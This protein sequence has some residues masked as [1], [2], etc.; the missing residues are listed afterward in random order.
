[1]A[2]VTA[3]P[4]AVTGSVTNITA[5]TANISATVNAKF[6]ASTPKLFIGTNLATIESCAA[7]SAPCAPSAT[8][9]RTASLATVLEGDTT[10]T[11]TG[12]I[13][14]LSANTTY[15]T[16]V[17]AQS[18]AGYSCGA[19]TT[20]STQLSIANNSMSATVN[21]FFSENLIANGGSGVYSNWT[22]ANNTAL[23]S[24]LT[25][26]ASTGVISGTPSVAT[27]ASFD[28][29]V[30][31]SLNATVIKTISIVVGSA[32]QVSQPQS[33][34]PSI[35]QITP[36]NVSTA[37]GTSVTLT[38]SNLQN[39]TISVGGRSVTPSNNTS[40]SLTFIVPAGLSG[41]IS[42]VVTNSL[43]ILTFSNAITATNPSTNQ[44]EPSRLTLVFD[45]FAPGSS[46]LTK[47]HLARLGSLKISPGASN[48]FSFKGSKS[49]TRD[50]ANYRSYRNLAGRQSAQS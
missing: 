50:F 11:V 18:V 33:Q 26:N 13:S 6:L 45:N 5:S 34:S 36:R 29:E 9:L 46:K 23:P 32:A 2:V 12:S 49:C 40:T 27:T 19:I 44:P 31:D 15:Y 25:L 42:L 28:I 14:G 39:S 22:L 41:Q 4:E 24:G 1:M 10:Q 8:V 38:G 48:L 37:G 30:T 35:S 21:Q 17:C 7:I 16:R 43:G 20:F 47:A 3:M